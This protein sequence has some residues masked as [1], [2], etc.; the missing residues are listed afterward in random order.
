[1][2][3]QPDWAFLAAS[4]PYQ[5]AIAVQKLLQEGKSMEAGEGLHALIDSMGRSEKRAL[6]SQLTRLMSHVIKWKCQPERRSPSWAITIRDARTEI[7]DSQ[8]EFP[9]LNRDHIESIWP[10]CFDRAIKDAEDEMGM[11]CSL[12]S[13]SWTEVFE[14]E[15][16]LLKPEAE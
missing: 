8:E 12:N 3:A 6:K 16:T 14:E 2:Q 10:K 1:M 9:S 5:T 4:S 13:L 7:A 15:Y 11:R